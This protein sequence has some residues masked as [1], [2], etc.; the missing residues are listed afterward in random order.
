MTPKVY[1]R[2][3]ARSFVYGGDRKA[4]VQLGT[5]IADSIPNEIHSIQQAMEKASL[6]IEYTKEYPELAKYAETFAGK[7]V[8]WSTHAAGIV[9]GRRSLRGLVPL[10]R[11][12]DGNIAV[13]YEKER[14]EMN[15]LVKM[16]MLGLETLDIIE[17]TYKNI[18]STGKPVPN[19]PN[20]EE[21]DK[22]TYDLISS[23]DTFG[24]F[25]LG[26]SA[27]T[28][29]LCKRVKPQNITDIA[30]INSLAR[31]SAKDIRQKYVDVRDGKTPIDI[32]HPSLHDALMPTLGFGLY[33]EALLYIAKSVAGWN[34]NKADKLR[35]FTKDKGKNPEKAKK[36]KNDFINDA[37]ANGIEPDMAKKI[38]TEVVESWSGYGFN[39][40]HAVFYSMI[41]YTTSWLKAHAPVEFAVANLK[42]E[43]LSNSKIAKD[44]ISRIK[45]EIRKLGVKILPPDLNTSEMTYKII[46]DHTLMT[47]L[48][49]LKYM[50]QDAIPEIL[51][52]RPFTSFEDFLIRT[53]GKK[54][55]AP[56]VQALAAAGCLDQFGVSRKLM[57]LY[58]A[59][60][61]KKLQAFNKRKKKVGE[62]SYPWPEEGDWTISEKCALERKWL[63]ESLSGDKIQ[64]Y[65]GFFT[66]KAINFKN[67]PKLLPPPPEDMDE[68]ERKRYSTRITS[69]QGELKSLWEFPV[70]KEGSKMQGEIMAKL[71]IEDPYGN[72]VGVTC[73]PDGWTKLKERC[74]SLSSNKGKLEPGVGLY[75]NGALQWYNDELSII[76][77]DLAKFSLPPQLPVDLK[78]KKIS[79]KVTKHPVEEKSQEEIDRT[80]LLSEIEDELSESGDA[81]LEEW[82]FEED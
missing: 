67:F 56:A 78:A 28:I 4:A 59:D 7:Y 49:S 66:N 52:K 25:Q 40:S 14:A 16:D 33:E 41:G 43:V 30:I 61:K 34:L 50:G 15:G 81:D 64:E 20:V 75:I 45:E 2:A 12:K 32:M 6:F 80:M 22:K 70:K 1:A 71:V 19:L 8:A 31:P 35:K 55:K 82:N 65:G 54:V 42:S 48:D 10:R 3:I 46:D 47:G 5:A 68:K 51:A 27:G 37:I 29:D 69:V 36:L 79:I 60:Y 9:I 26:T 62:F 53:D 17:D 58:S 73:F 13:E 76:F 63:G 21:Y 38:W 44:N 23:G 74:I 39:L 77:E 57:F 24:V 72:Q 11:D 18:A